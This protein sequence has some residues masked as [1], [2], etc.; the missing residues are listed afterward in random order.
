MNTEQPIA[1]NP[2]KKYFRQPKLYIKLPSSGN[3]YPAGALEMTDTGEFPVYAMTAKDEIAMKTPDALMNGQSTVDVIQSCVPNVKNGWVVPSIDVDA[4]LVAIRMATYGETID[5]DVTIPGTDIS[6]TYVADLRVVLDN[7]LNAVFD[8]EVK[9]ND[10]MRAVIRPLT[11][12]EVTQ[13]SIKTLEEQ[14]IFGIVNDDSIPDDRKIELFNKSF[15]ALT[16]ITI[17][18]VSK[19]VVKIVV[20]DAEVSDPGHISEFIENADKDFYNA[21]MR[22]FESQKERFKI[23]SFEVETTEYERENGAPESFKFPIELD[24]ANFFA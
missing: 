8:T 15:R 1:Q 18:M 12:L 9:I 7:L 22:H 23:P 3:F 13:S 24:A 5:I 4:I 21:V 6:K 17:G 19:S 20:D 11:Y 2:L 10:T 16:Q 14:R